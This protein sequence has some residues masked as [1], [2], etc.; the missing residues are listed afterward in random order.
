M[1][2]AKKC[3]TSAVKSVD[4]KLRDYNFKEFFICCLFL[5]GDSFKINI[6][7]KELFNA[8]VDQILI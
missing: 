8:R 7:S 1:E 4:I 6:D 5:L 2:R 3:V